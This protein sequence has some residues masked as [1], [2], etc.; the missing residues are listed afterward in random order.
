ML[1][2]SN[3]IALMAALHA[4]RRKPDPTLPNGQDVLLFTLPLFHVFGFFVVVRGGGYGR[5]LG[6]D[7][8]L[9]FVFDSKITSFQVFGTKSAR[10]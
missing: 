1:T 10:E 3:F 5:D 6:I 8:A 9:W 7:G 2:H 4:L